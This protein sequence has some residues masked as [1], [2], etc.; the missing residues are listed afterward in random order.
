MI[1]N[2]IFDMGGVLIEWDPIRFLQRFGVKD[3]NEIQT[4]LNNTVRKKYWTDYDLGRIDLDT[5]VNKSLKGL[6]KHLHKYAILFIRDWA[7]VSNPI[8]G[9]IEYTN[10]LKKK[11]YKLYLLSNAGKN[12]PYYFRRFPYKHFDGRCVSAFYGVGKPDK[13][14]FDALLNKYKLKAQE[15]V[16]TDDMKANIAAANSYGIKAYQFK[17]AKQIKKDFGL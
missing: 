10:Y 16:F 4:I 7:S 6:P 14:F 2:V 13:E 8:E 5:L 17:S 1:K 9:M 3:D 11:G 15:C 12:Q